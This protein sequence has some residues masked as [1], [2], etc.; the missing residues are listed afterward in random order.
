MLQQA[1]AEDFVIATGKTVSLEYFVEK[2]FAYFGLNWRQYVES[3]VSLLRPSDIR[4]GCANPVKAK[5][6]LG[7]RSMTDVD[8]VIREMCAATRRQ[9]P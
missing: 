3:D 4:F 1:K 9:P 7:W 2:T 6:L 5:E 8:G